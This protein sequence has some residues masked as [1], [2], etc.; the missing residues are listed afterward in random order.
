MRRV[1]HRRVV[2]DDIGSSIPR[3]GQSCAYLKCEAP[4]ESSSEN[5]RQWT[6]RTRIVGRFSGGA[7]TTSQSV[8][9]SSRKKKQSRMPVRKFARYWHVSL[10]GLSQYQR[11]CACPW[12]WKKKWRQGTI[13]NVDLR[14]ASS[15]EKSNNI[16]MVLTPL[17]WGLGIQVHWLD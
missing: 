17:C 7:L 8:D 4:P 12:G 13:R 14:Y 15:T 9:G 6:R 11:P 10:L 3:M 1:P 2:R 5:S 16:T